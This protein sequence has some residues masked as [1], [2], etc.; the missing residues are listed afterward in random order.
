MQILKKWKYKITLNNSL[1]EFGGLKFRGFRL[2]FHG[3]VLEEDEEEL[4]KNG[5]IQVED[6]GVRR[7]Q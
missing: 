5:G 2:K 6:Y 4:E 7:E 3:F 1:K